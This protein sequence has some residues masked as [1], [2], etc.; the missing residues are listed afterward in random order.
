M[1]RERERTRERER[2]RVIFL[3][4]TTSSPTSTPIPSH[5]LPFS[6]TVATAGLEIINIQP[7][8][9]ATN[10]RFASYKA[11]GAREEKKSLFS[12]EGL[13]LTFD[14]KFLLKP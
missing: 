14:F 7:Q 2:E 6:P 4:A 12:F 1:R 8:V 3:K 13:S 11:Q 10:L 5:S 9:I